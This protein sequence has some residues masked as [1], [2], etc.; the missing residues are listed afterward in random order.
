MGREAQWGM[1][2]KEEKRLFGWDGATIRTVY[3]QEPTSFGV[4]ISEMRTK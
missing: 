4:L 3:S 2:L 1:Y